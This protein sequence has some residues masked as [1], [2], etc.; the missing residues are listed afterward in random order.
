MKDVCRLDEAPIGLFMSDGEL[1]LKTEYREPNGAISAF[2]VS[3][4][5]FFWGPSPQ[6]VA[7]QNAADV[8]P[9]SE[10]AVVQFLIASGEVP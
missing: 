7:T 1:C 3:S 8:R 5:E 9:I 4:G 6:S 2:I 10:D